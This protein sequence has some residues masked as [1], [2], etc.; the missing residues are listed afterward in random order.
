[1]LALLGFYVPFLGI[2]VTFLWPVPIAMIAVRHGMRTSVMTVV[3]AGAVLS[4]VVGLL[5]GA[6]M[7]FVMGLVG[8]ALGYALLKRWNPVNTVLL[9]TVAVVI[10]TVTS[11]SISI[12][13]FDL[14]ISMMFE[15]MAEAATRVAEIYERFGVSRDTLEPFTAV[16]TQAIDLMRLILPAILLV[17]GLVNA[18]LNYEVARRV[19][20]RFGYNMQ[21][22]PGFAEWRFPSWAALGFIGGQ[23]A[24][25][26]YGAG[27]IELFGRTLHLG[28]ESLLLFNTAANVAFASQFLLV[29]QGLSLAYHFLMRFRM[30]RGISVFILA[31]AWFNPTMSQI[32]LMFG[33]MDAV[34]DYRR[35][36]AAV[37]K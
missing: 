32:I 29:V 28:H 16:W 31:W 35:F 4:M 22:L 18:V 27:A 9:A 20:S 14:N 23:V 3:V 2:F 8:L 10:G 12:L 34:F 13:F 26:L 17:G 6:L 15:Q 36:G 25:A 1:M 24:A 33:L 21:P 30:P 11:F 7:T 19:M 5:E 37:K